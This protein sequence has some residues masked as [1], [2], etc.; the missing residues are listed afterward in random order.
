[1]H[2]RPRG[3]APSAP[4]RVWGPPGLNGRISRPYHAPLRFQTAVGSHQSSQ[5][6]PPLPFLPFRPPL[7][8]LTSQIEILLPPRLGFR[9]LPR[10]STTQ[11][12]AAAVAAWKQ[13]HLVALDFPAAARLSFLFARSPAGPPIA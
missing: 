12:A 9:F 2:G 3:P 7:V 1:V 13:S 5:L 6:L 4:H 11:A 8:L 10:P